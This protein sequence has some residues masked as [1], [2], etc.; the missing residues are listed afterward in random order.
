VV[1]LNPACQIFKVSVILGSD[2]ALLDQELPQGEKASGR[3]GGPCFL[4]LPGIY[5]GYPN[6]QDTNQNMAVGNHG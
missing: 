1:F 2:P 5:Q 4:I 6:G 3:T